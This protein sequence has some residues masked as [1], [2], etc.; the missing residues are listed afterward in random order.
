M[1]PTTLR[2]VVGFVTLL[3]EKFFLEYYYQLTILTNKIR[4]HAAIRISPSGIF[5]Q[6][7]TIRPI[8]CLESRGGVDVII[9]SNIKKRIAK[10]EEG[11]VLF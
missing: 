6:G 3:T 4:N 7:F 5:E 2:Q 9:V 10:Y 8:I 11:G 1:E